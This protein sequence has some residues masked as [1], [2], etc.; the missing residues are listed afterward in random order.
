MQ[1]GSTFTLY[2]TYDCRAPSTYRDREPQSHMVLNS[3]TVFFEVVN[4]TEDQTYSCMCSSV[5]VS[6]GDKKTCG[7]DITVGCEFLHFL[8]R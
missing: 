6:S 1:V 7:I 8:L 5:S 2:C 3:S 4:I